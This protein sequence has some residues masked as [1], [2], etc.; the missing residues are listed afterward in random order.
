[1]DAEIFFRVRKIFG[2]S[3]ITVKDGDKVI[4]SLKRAHMAPGE[5]ERV[6]L[7]RAL[8]DAIEGDDISVSVEEAD[9]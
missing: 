6:R 9:E 8:L 3:R 7:S 2:T 1:M 5:M 4:A